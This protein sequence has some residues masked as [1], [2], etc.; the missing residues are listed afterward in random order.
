MALGPSPPVSS[1]SVAAGVLG[2]VAAGVLGAVATI[3]LGISD[4]ASVLG[5]ADVASR[6]LLI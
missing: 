2:A 3:A 1:G 4:L 6:V 5:I